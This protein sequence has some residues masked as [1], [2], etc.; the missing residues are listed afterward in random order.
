MDMS[1]RTDHHWSTHLWMLSWVQQRNITLSC[2]PGGRG[3]RALCGLPRERMSMRRIYT[4]TRQPEF[5]AM[6][7]TASH[8]L[9]IIH[10]LFL[11][12]KIGYISPSP[13]QTD[14]T[15]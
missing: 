1:E 6:G 11:G 2:L 4:E 13:S 15:M 8:L 14:V 12:T 5:Q 9:K 10:S 3:E 7:E